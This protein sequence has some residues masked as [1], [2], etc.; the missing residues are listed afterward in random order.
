VQM[1]R[2]GDRLFATTEG[3]GHLIVFD[4]TRREVVHTAPI[5]H[6]PGCLFGLEYRD[7]DG[8]LYAISGQSVVRIR[9]EDYSVELLGTWPELAYGMGMAADAIY[10]CAGTSLVK[11]TIPPGAAQEP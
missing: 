7:A 8:M 6:G 9:P 5:G 10:L 4:I 2:V 1:A 3:E 11:L